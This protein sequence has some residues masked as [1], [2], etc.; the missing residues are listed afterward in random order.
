MKKNAKAVVLACAIMTCVSAANARTKGNYLGFSL[1]GSSVGIEERDSSFF[2]LGTVR[3]VSFNYMYAIN[4]KNFVLAPE[5][6]YFVGLASGW[7][8]TYVAKAH[9]GYDIT[10][11]LTLLANVAFESNN[12]LLEKESIN[13]GVAAMYRLDKNWNL[14]ASL[15]VR[16]KGIDIETTSIGLS[17]NF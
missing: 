8:E 10:E 12:N 1:T 7:Q 13:Y 9:I 16:Q 4:Y 17:C 6:V 11:N 15:E 5:F 3:D 14:Q 2:Y